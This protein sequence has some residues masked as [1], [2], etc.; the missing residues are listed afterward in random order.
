MPKS[1]IQ[2]IPIMHLITLLNDEIRMTQVVK[3]LKELRKLQR[4]SIATL[5]SQSS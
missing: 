1:E 2:A 4:L 5:F 3:T